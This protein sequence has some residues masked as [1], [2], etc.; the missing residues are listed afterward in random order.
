[1]LSGKDIQSPKH[2]GNQKNHFQM[3]AIFLINTNITTN[4]EYINPRDRF[5][6]IVDQ[7]CRRIGLVF[8]EY[9]WPVWESLL[10]LRRYK[11]SYCWLSSRIPPLQNPTTDFLL[12]S[13]LICPPLVFTNKDLSPLSLFPIHLNPS[14]PSFEK[15]TKSITFNTSCKANTPP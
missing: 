11:L 4:Y 5:S 13:P 14:L 7:R 9:V 12:M 6:V 3:T 2:H 8:S 10:F 1:M 15:I